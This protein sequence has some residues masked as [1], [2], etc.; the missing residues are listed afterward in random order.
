MRSQASSAASN[1]LLASPARQ[2]ILEVLSSYRPAAGHVA[3]GG[4]TAA[5][6]GEAVGLHPTTVRFHADRLEAAGFLRSRFTTQFGVGRPRKVYT[7]ATS[8]EPNDHTTQLNRLTELLTE[9]FGSGRTPDQAGEH[10][11]RGHVRLERSEPATTPGAWLTKVGRLLDILQR[12]GYT[13][14]VT[15]SD[16]GRTCRIDLV[17]CPF[18][19][20]A[21]A[22]P[23]VVCGIHRGLLTGAL[24]QLGEDQVDVSLRP[25]VGPTLCHA[26]LSTRQPFETQAEESTDE[27]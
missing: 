16:G 14:N 2:R 4:L 10:W 19:D 1:D 25:F 23:D 8:S 26:Y 3:P 20:L 15:T 17:D 13:P 27:P 12:W 18:F 24:D 21:Q 11:V 5:Q 22:K 9:E 6:I 7:V